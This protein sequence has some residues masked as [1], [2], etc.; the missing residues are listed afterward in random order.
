SQFPVDVFPPK[1]ASFV[2]RVA[3]AI[4][5]PLDFVGVPVLVVSGAAAG[6]ARSVRVKAG[7]FEK[8][9]LY[10]VIVSRP[11]TTKSPALR[12]VMTPLYDE[13]ARVYEAYKAANREYEQGLADYKDPKRH[14]ADDAPELGPPPQPPVLRHVFASDT[15]V[16][17]LA[18]NLEE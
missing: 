8:P 9:S 6:A 14:K 4:G 1:V 18:A 2:R 10:A 11:G 7:W 17:G 5:C 13:Q 15:T 3:A 16:E 12:A